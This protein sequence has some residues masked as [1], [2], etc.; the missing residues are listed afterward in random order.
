[1]DL[2]DRDV[3]YIYRQQRHDF[4]NHVQIILG[5]LQIGKSDRAV[6]YIHRVMDEADDERSIFRL[7]PESVLNLLKLK[8]ALRKQGINLVIKVDDIVSEV[9]VGDIPVDAIKACGSNVELFIKKSKKG[10]EYALNERGGG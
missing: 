9:D 5:Y 4:L 7:D 2:N 10:I 3:I 6:D 1:M 8:Y